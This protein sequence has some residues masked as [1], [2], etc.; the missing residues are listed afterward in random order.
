[1]PSPVGSLHGRYHPE[2]TIVLGLYK[3]STPGVDVG[4]DATTILGEDSEPQPDLYLRLLPEYRGQS[5]I[6]ADGFIEG[7]PEFVAEISHSS[8]AIDL[9][10]KKDDY[11]KAGVQEYFVLSIE[12]QE[13]FW[14]HF[15]SR[16]KLKPDKS[17]VWRSKIF[18][19][20]WVDGP[21]LLSFDTPKLIETINQG[22]AS[23][24]HAEFLDLLQQNKT[25]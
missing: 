6:N 2:L 1:M 23:K 24:K 12:Q 4:I 5:F 8:V 15:P 22:I 25:A 10:A 9:D 3:A 7:P 19:G 18:P 21:A 17:G 11:L 14:F 13:I 20:L 16:R